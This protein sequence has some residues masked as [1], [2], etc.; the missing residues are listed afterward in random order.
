MKKYYLT[1]P[2]LACRKM[3]RG[4]EGQA[5]LL[6]FGSNYSGKNY[7][8]GWAGICR[9]AFSDDILAELIHGE[10]FFSPF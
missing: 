10:C 5:C 2:T 1:M 7:R 8:N 6:S 9:Q 3:R 4:N